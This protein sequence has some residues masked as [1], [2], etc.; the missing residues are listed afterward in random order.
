MGFIVS[1]AEASFSDCDQAGERRGSGDYVFWSSSGRV[2]D[3]NATAR[4]RGRKLPSH[5]G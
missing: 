5:G 3:G 4:P 2:M 1:L